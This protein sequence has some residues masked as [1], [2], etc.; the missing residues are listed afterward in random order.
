MK[1][2]VLTQVAGCTQNVLSEILS[3]YGILYLP[4]FKD[5]AKAI[6]QRLKNRLLSLEHSSVIVSTKPSFYTY[7]K[8]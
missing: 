6:E 8:G 1:T 4:H 2:G 5:Q 7:I 3:S